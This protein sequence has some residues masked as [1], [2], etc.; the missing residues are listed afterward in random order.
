MGSQFVIWSAPWAARPS[1]QPWLLYLAAI[2]ATG[3]NVQ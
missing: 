3:Q 2:P 1:V